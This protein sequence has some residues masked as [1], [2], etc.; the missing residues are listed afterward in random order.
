[1]KREFC[2]NFL[3]KE[4]NIFCKEKKKWK[5]FFKKR[6]LCEIFYICK[7]FPF[8]WKFP[9]FFNSIFNRF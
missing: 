9:N 1:M 8:F 7:T 4:N 3:L 6:K 5:N 2:E